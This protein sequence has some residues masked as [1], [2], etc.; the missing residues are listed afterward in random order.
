MNCDDFINPSLSDVNKNV[1]KE[2]CVYERSELF[3]KYA[4]LFI[5]KRK[6][7]LQSKTVYA[8]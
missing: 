2:Q 1:C 6:L 7:N 8:D 4:G 5:M 3:C